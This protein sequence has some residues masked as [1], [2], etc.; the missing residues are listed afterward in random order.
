[1]YSI[2]VSTRQS[3]ESVHQLYYITVTLTI[4]HKSHT[5]IDLLINVQPQFFFTNFYTNFCNYVISFN[6]MPQYETNTHKTITISN[7]GNN[8]LKQ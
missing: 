5:S 2:E 1:M 3:R 6:K 4:I 7:V 8:K